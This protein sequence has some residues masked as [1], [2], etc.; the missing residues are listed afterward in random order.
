MARMMRARRMNP[1]NLDRIF[2]EI[3]LENPDVATRPNPPWIKSES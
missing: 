1:S 2:N 3:R